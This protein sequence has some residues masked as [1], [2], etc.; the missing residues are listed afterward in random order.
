MTGSF[1]TKSSDLAGLSVRWHWPPRHHCP[2]LPRPSNLIMI[3]TSE[4]LHYIKEKDCFVI[5]LLLIEHVVANEIS[6]IA[7]TMFLTCS[8][9]LV[10]P[11][12]LSSVGVCLTVTLCLSVCLFVSL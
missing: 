2:H 4:A 11:N 12:F 9:T 5:L 8:L 6:F 3:L 7:K 10:P 1:L